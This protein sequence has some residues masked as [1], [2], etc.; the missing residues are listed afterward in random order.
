MPPRIPP[1][2]LHKVRGNGL[3]RTPPM[4]WNSWN[5]Y[6]CRIDEG[7]IRGVAD[8]MVTNG[9]R[10]AGYTYV[11]IDDCWQGERDKD[12]FIQADPTTNTLIITANDTIRSDEQYVEGGYHPVFQLKRGKISAVSLL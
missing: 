7:L 2:T 4:G 11:N 9:M 12:G 8:A 6:G 3:A 10:D 1:P 5:R